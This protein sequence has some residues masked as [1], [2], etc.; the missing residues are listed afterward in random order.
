MKHRFINL[1]VYQYIVHQVRRLSKMITFKA[2]VPKVIAFN[3]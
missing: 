2:T 1:D 3:G